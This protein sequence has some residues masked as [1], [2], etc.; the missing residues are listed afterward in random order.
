MSNKQ[1]PASVDRDKLRSKVLRFDTAITRSPANA[2]P[3]YLPVQECD[4]Y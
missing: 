1:E 4:V 2:H 3:M